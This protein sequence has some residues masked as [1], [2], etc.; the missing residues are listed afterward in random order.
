MKNDRPGSEM[1]HTWPCGGCGR[2][3]SSHTDNE[4]QTQA[5][6]PPGS[7]HGKKKTKQKK[8]QHIWN[9]FD[10]T[11]P[12]PLL[13]GPP[14]T[15]TPT[16]TPHQAFT[17]PVSVFLSSSSYQRL[18]VAA[19]SFVTP[20]DTHSVTHTRL[21]QQ[22]VLPVGEGKKK[23]KEKSACHG[24]SPSPSIGRYL[25]ILIGHLGRVTAT[26]SAGSLTSVLQADN[27]C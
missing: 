25:R 5:G 11:A 14:T 24:P 26:P 2:T 20:C 9:R 12:L 19:S 4:S 18:L 1:Q 6:T 13:P 16:P 27:I 15:T 21:Q 17:M 3:T 23:E 8:P 10:G 7:E 22:D